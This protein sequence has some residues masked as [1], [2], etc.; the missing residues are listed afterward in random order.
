MYSVAV[1]GAGIVGLTT[2]FTI[3]KRLGSAVNVTVF[4]ENFTPNTTSDVAAG[5]LSPYIWD[6]M[7]LDDTM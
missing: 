2:A 1:V 4:A 6:N 3:Q 7:S 5:V